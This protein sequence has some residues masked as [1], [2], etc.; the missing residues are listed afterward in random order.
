[1]TLMQHLKHL[2][3]MP[4]DGAELND[5]FVLEH[6]SKTLTFYFVKIVRNSRNLAKRTKTPASVRFPK[7]VSFDKTLTNL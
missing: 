7:I 3:I 5:F 6:F 4:L 1:M 2:M